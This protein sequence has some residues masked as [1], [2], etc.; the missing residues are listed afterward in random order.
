MLSKRRVKEIFA[1][2]DYGSIVNNGPKNVSHEV[3]PK[4]L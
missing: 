4:D 2:V 3:C 1:F